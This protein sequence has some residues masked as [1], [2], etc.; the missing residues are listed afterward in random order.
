[1][2][3]LGRKVGERKSEISGNRGGAGFLGSAI[4]RY[5]INNLGHEVVNLD[6]LTYAGNL[7]SLPDILNSAVSIHYSV[8]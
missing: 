3:L 6:R 7:E 2:K 8:T 5:L 1:M 4:I